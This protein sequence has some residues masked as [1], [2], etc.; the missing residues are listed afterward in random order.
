[1]TGERELEE[2]ADLATLM[3]AADTTTL[4]QLSDL[5]SEDYELDAEAL[6]DGKQL[7]VRFGT[8]GVG[9]EFPIRIDAFWETLDELHAEASDEVELDDDE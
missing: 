3:S 9:F 7:T 4:E 5:I 1:M 2:F 8:R 6:L